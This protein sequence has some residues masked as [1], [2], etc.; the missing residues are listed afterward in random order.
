MLQRWLYGRRFYDEGNG[1]GGEGSGGETPPAETPPVEQKPEKT[2]TQKDIDA[3]IKARLDREGIAELKRKASEFDKIE[4]ANK[5]EQQRLQDALAAA[6][7]ERDEARAESQ[8]RLLRADFVSK[9]AEQG[10]KRPEAAYKLAL[11]EGLTGSLDD[12]GQ[13][14]AHDFTGLKAAYP[15]LFQVGAAGRGDGAAQ[16][17]HGTGK[18]GLREALTSRYKRG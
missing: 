6:Q 11:A 17:Q 18:Q 4:E 2:F 9:A 7:R 8:Q 5:T 10:V 15:E 16:G 3:A 1:G 14:G 13:V 12:K